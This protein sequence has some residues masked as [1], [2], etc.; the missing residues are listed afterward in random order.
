MGY[1]PIQCTR[2]YLSLWKLIDRLFPDSKWLEA[3]DI[4]IGELWGNV[5]NILRSDNLNWC[6]SPSILTNY[7]QAVVTLTDMRLDPDLISSADRL[8]LELLD[9]ALEY[10]KQVD[11]NSSEW[12][13]AFRWYVYA[14]TITT[15]P[16]R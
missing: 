12:E 5:N 2:A 14:P 7:A 11:S 3:G 9:K 16:G 6:D 15:G 10:A 13:N 4:R 1:D 8:R